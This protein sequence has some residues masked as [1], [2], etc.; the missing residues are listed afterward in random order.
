M[1]LIKNLISIKIWASK[2]SIKTIQE[3]MAIPIRL[4]KYHLDFNQNY[5]I[6]LLNKFNRGILILIKIRKLQI[7]ILIIHKRN[8]KKD[9]WQ[10]IFHIKYYQSNNWKF[11]HRINYNNQKQ[12][13]IKNQIFKNN[14]IIINIYL[15]RKA[16]NTTNMNNCRMIIGRH[17]ELYLI[18]LNRRKIVILIFGIPVSIIMTY[19]K[20]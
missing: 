17:F 19:N 14:K 9:F 6:S 20:I 15:Q 18:N 11:Y 3:I 2:L 10:R 1:K 5:L 7:S 4:L 8:M 12:I 13:Y 16:F